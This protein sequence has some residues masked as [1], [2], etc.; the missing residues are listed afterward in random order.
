MCIQLP[1]NQ[2]V[3]LVSFSSYTVDLALH[4]F[5]ELF[6]ELVELKVTLNDLVYPSLHVSL[7]CFWLLETKSIQA[8]P[9]E[10][11]WQLRTREISLE[12]LSQGSDLTSCV[13]QGGR[14]LSHLLFE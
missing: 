2:V 13:V 12:L 3:G 5:S 10:Q 11:I 6:D 9:L 14:D 8:W 4:T 7:L 1:N